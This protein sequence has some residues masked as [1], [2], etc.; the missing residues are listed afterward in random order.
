MI[1]SIKTPKK[2]NP[3]RQLTSLNIP[4]QDLTNTNQKQLISKNDAKWKNRL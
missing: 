3:A 1:A 4:E 2:K